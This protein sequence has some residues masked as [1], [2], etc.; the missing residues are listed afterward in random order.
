MFWVLGQ[1]LTTHETEMMQLM[2]H[3]GPMLKKPESPG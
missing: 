2:R 1:Y 3:V